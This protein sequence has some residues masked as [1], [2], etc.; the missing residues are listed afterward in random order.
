MPKLIDTAEVRR[1]GKGARKTVYIVR[2]SLTARAVPT[3]SA[4]NGGHGAQM[5]AFAHPT[6]L[7]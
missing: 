6:L 5:R 4:G 7:L 2:A 1:V 3:R